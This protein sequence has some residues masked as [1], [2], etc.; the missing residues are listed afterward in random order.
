MFLYIFSPKV[1]FGHDL[2][3]KSNTQ[4]WIFSSLSSLPSWTSLSVKQGWSQC[5]F[6]ELVDWDW[7]RS[8]NS[9]GVR[10]HK[11]WWSQKIPLLKISWIIFSNSTFNHFLWTDVHDAFLHHNR[12]IWLAMPYTPLYRFTIFTQTFWMILIPTFST[13]K[14]VKKINCFL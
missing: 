6:I 8:V 5:G 11:T 2:S 13:W 9:Q 3:T 14:I 10:W 12:L 7:I 1:L 4:P